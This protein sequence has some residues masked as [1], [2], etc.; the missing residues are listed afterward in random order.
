MRWNASRKIGIAFLYI[1][2]IENPTVIGAA[3]D[4]MGWN[5]ERADGAFHS[6]LIFESPPHPC[7][8]FAIR[9]SESG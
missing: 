6:P 7:T 5:G 8:S 2:P 4:R 3:V 9:M 1:E